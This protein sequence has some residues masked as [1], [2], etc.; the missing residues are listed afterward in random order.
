[1][2]EPDP[3]HPDNFLT[4]ATFGERFFRSAVTKERIEG[5][6]ASLGGRTISFGPI[7][8]GPLELVKVSAEGEVRAPVVDERPGDLVAFTLRVPVDLHLVID[9][10]LDKSRF[11]AVVVARLALTA[12]AADPL[13][14][15]I[16]IEDPTPQHIDV[17]VQA[18]GVRASVLQVLAGVDREI[19]KSVA[20]YIKRE[21][22]KPGLRA[23]RTIDVGKAL[24]GFRLKR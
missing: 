11:N 10:G 1:M 24:D 9:M 4:Y 12:R 2:S 17:T 16:D 18:E 5:G 20:R 15:V 6:V 3:L 14:I 13:V 22:D 8:V 23:A 21:I 7:G 19:K